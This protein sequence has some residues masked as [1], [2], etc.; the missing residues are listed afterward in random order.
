MDGA[1]RHTFGIPATCPFT[2][3]EIRL[4]GITGSNT[5]LI[6]ERDEYGEF[7]HIYAKLCSAPGSSTSPDEY[8][9]RHD[10]YSRYLK[11][12]D[13]EN[14]PHKSSKVIVLSDSGCGTEVP[15]ASTGSSSLSYPPAY[16]D[17]QRPYTVRARPEVWNIGTFLEYTIN[18]GGR[19]PYLVMTT[20]CHYDHIM[21]IGKLLSSSTSTTVL[22][23]SHAKTFVSPYA[24]LQKHSLCNTLNL[25]APKYDVGLW[26][27]DL[28]RVA[29]TPGLDPSP[30]SGGNTIP[31]PFT[32]L[33]TPGH[34]PDSLSWYDSE[35]RL[36]C[37]GDSFY[38]KET[39]T[40]RDA[41]WGH[42]P[43]MPVMFSLESDL[44]DWWRSLDK[45]L[46]FV[47]KKNK[48]VG[49]NAQGESEGDM[50]ERSDSP[51]HGHKSDLQKN[52][53]GEIEDEGFVLINVDNAAR[54]TD[55]INALVTKTKHLSLASSTA[56]AAAA[57]KSATAVKSQKQT[58]FDNLPRSEKSFAVWPTT[59]T[60]SL[61]KP[62]ILPT[63]A[64]NKGGFPPGALPFSPSGLNPDPWM[65]VVNRH[66][67]LP[68]PTTSPPHPPFPDRQLSSPNQLTT[69]L[70]SSSSHGQRQRKPCA[71][72]A[73]NTGPLPRVK[74]CA[75][76]TT[77]S[78]DAEH[79]LVSMRGF[80]LRVLKGEVPC[81]RVED[82]P[83]GEERWLWDSAIPASE[84]D[85]ARRPLPPTARAWGYW[86][87][88]SPAEVARREVDKRDV[89]VEMAGRAQGR[90]HQ[91]QAK[92]MYSVL[93]PLRVIEAGRKQIL[94]L[95]YGGTRR[96]AGVV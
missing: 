75:A 51:T 10:S 58:G 78:L 53:D 36:L 89:D 76:H 92:H 61:L 90:R 64:A 55:D 79:A 17:R 67:P 57:T 45:V 16:D 63:S 80:L 6:R 96:P 39:S 87:A 86:V 94:E 12:G 21:G 68:W 71:P 33:H 83:H 29:Y 93:A 32:I 85:V 47:R 30:H 23:S 28:S 88:E 73:S 43:A 72:S 77:L 9:Y 70:D 66:G 3:Q 82:G 56:T 84:D 54:D 26:A 14:K 95:D 81:Q 31:T 22:T 1:G 44:K 35:L 50:G 48:E 74:L 11:D 27:D 25:D 59:S 20:H 46:Q 49:G 38:A 62:T 15:N 69:T 40:T 60:N 91:E 8:V 41:T 19:I 5:Y 7:P 2:I 13:F 37:V 4:N 24:N 52:K 18:P 42:E 65:L 34:T